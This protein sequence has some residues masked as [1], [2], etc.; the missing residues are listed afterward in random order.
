MTRL[1]T[2]CARVTVGSLVA[3][4]ILAGFTPAANAANTGG[5]NR[6]GACLA[7]AKA[8]DLLLLFDES[9]SL[10][11]SDPNA[12]RVAAAKPLLQTL[13]RY[14]DRVGANLDVA[15]AG[16]ADTYTPEKDWTRLTESSADGTAAALSDIASKNTG[17][18]TD[19]WLALDG[20]RQALAGRGA[21]RCQAIAW[22]SDGKIDFTPRPGSKPYADGIDLDDP[23]NVEQIR[24]RAIESICR[25]GGL[26]DQVRSSNIVML[27]IGLGANNSPADFDVMSAISTGTGLNGKRCGEIT[28]PVP[29]DFYP[30]ANI[31]DMLFAF[32]SLNPDP[33]VNRQG[34][35]CQLQV[36][37]EARHN[38]VLDRSIK[39]VNIL[40][41]GG[42]PGVVPYLVA[43]G[44]ET[45]ELPKRDGRSD[46]EIAGIAV[47]YEW[48]S[49]SAQTI[50]IVNSGTPA[51]A[52]QW[53][54]VYVDTTGEHADAV[55][56]VNIHITTD[57]FPALSNAKDVSWRSGQVVEDLEF[58]LVDGKDKPVSA[59]DLAGTA[60]LSATLVPDGAEPIGIVDAAT[61]E[62]LGKPVSVDL[63]AVEPGRA[64]LRMSLVI[65]TAPALDPQ[66]GQI[67]PGTELSPQ[68][69]EV[70]VQILP[71]LGL[72]TPGARIDF[73]TVQAAE[74][75]TATLSV[76][77]PGCVWIADADGV[78]ITAGPDDIGT[79]RVTAQ[80]NSP[81]SC[82]KVPSGETGALT[83][84]LRTDRDGHGGL[85]GTV[86]VHVAAL[87]DPGDSQVV[88]VAFV[89]SLIKP[90]NTTNFILVL[91]AALLLGPGIPLALLYASKWWVTRIPDTPLLAE[92]IPIQ[93][94]GD[95]VLR[96][97]E[98]FAMRD[99]DLIQPVPG[100]TGGGVRR[101]EVL[102]VV[103]SAVTGRS[104]FG[105]GH[106][107]VDA[108]GRLSVGSELPG[109]DQSGLRAV[110]PLAVHNKWVVLHDPQGPADQAEVL[111]LVSGN[112]DTAA[113]E[114][115]Y[116]KIADRLPDLLNGLRMR[117]TH[118]GLAVPAEAGAH[119]ASPFGGDSGG[120]GAAPGFDP[121]GG[122]APMP[123]SAPA[124]A[125]A[126][127]P[128]PS[129]GDPFGAADPFGGYGCAPTAAPS[130]A[131]SGPAVPAR[132]GY[133]A[134]TPAPEGPDPYERTRPAPAG[135]RPGGEQR[136]PRP[137]HRAPQGP[138]QQGPPRPVP[139]P[140]QGPCLL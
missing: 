6:F 14:A 3:M 137:E 5:A 129:S 90:L 19:Y 22:F 1:T 72:P 46:A 127:G 124:D 80:A 135:Y 44:G 79:P 138:P 95:E 30:V 20:A 62:D 26:A 84:T 132:P 87:D 40:G 83:V 109:S 131:Q 41:S 108:D 38:F 118:A 122:A 99:K 43:P 33:G 123:P 89:A 27:G 121:F 125:P 85:N 120:A 34:P 103:L 71:K 21:D 68:D 107:T 28:D 16:F 70:P 140:P 93:V 4:L 51:W 77:G 73:G 53:A 60:T 29:G 98:P 65:T 37:P 92:R 66:G 57:I 7:S 117:A 110:L 69:V 11:Q 102:G 54:I 15:V 31:D 94:R 55:S 8:G 111:L 45:L 130:P 59:A 133:D 91:I 126:H 76:T 116:A 101:L 56:R 113:R 52:G 64:V 81:E 119:V 47:H 114:Q 115:I 100:L 17:I 61:K 112:T 63:S 139:G 75:A 42:M 96:D 134:P 24:Q 35:V 12:A 78:T 74:G 58:G 105:A 128:G 49:E 9:S 88:E 23:A 2:L 82:L 10:Q 50:S 136:G 104:P 106:V 97:G 18:D 36:C 25:P 86:P 32:D 48:Q 67:A 13:G 39:S